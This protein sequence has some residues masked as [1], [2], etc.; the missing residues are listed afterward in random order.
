MRPD[1]RGRLRELRVVFRV[2]A[3][4]RLS[5]HS[6]PCLAKPRQPPMSPWTPGILPCKNKRFS[7]VRERPI[8]FAFLPF[9]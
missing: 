7:V 9:P 2:R 6:T 4:E 5:A 1:L 3:I 8:Y